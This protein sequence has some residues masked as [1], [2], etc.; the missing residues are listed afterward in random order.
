MLSLFSTRLVDQLDCLVA[1]WW[2][3]CFN[4]FD[5]VDYQCHSVSSVVE[6]KDAAKESLKYVEQ[7]LK[8]LMQN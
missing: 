8:T 4:G 1:V 3:V 5:W 2:I 6:N 7:D